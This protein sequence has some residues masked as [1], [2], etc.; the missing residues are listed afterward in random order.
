M[1]R[2]GRGCNGG[3]S[4]G[5]GAAARLGREHNSVSYSPIRTGWESRCTLVL[6]GYLLL[7][8]PYGVV[9]S[10]DGS[11]VYVTNIRSNTV[12]VIAVHPGRSCS[13]PHHKDVG[14]ICF[15]PYEIFTAILS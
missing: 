4:R 10:P 2:V 9:V 8:D 14:R 12:S 5:S 15:A 7:P 13:V 1:G 3:E 6:D 11:A